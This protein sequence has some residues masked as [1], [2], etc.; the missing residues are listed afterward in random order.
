MQVFLLIHVLFEN[1]FHLS[2][3]ISG[4]FL[5]LKKGLARSNPK[6]PDLRREKAEKR[7]KRES[8]Q[9]QEVHNTLSLLSP[10]IKGVPAAGFDGI[11]WRDNWRGRG[12]S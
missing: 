2:E 12:E 1:K 5:E 4:V 9:Q 11:S 3:N 10:V 7:E 6:D 8:R